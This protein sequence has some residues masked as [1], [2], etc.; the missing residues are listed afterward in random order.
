[1]ERV[2]KILEHPL[3]QDYQKRLDALE[4]NRIFCKHGFEHAISVARILYIMVLE[5]GLAYTKSVIYGTALLHDLGRVQQYENGTPHDEASV[6]IAKQV[7]EDCGYV[8]EE[9]DIMLTAIHGHRQDDVLQDSF[10]LLFYKA[11]KISRECYHCEAA[12]DC[13]WAQEKR[14]HTIRY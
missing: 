5:Q 9:I 3:F 13:Y 10:S 6:K 1:M 8:K 11:D 12:D 7:L 14:N 2:N 4:R